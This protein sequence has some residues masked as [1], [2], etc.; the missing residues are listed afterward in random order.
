V[1][2][3]VIVIAADGMEI[4]LLIEE[5]TSGTQVKARPDVQVPVALRFVPTTRWIFAVDSVN[6]LSHLEGKNVSVLADGYVIASP[7]NSDYDVL[8]VTG[9]T[10]NLPKP[11]GVI[12]VG[13]PYISDLE[14]LDIDTPSGPS[15]KTRKIS[16]ANVVLEVEKSRGG[17][18]G[19]PTGPT[20]TDPLNGLDE[21]KY[22]GDEDDE[23]GPVQFKTD[24]VEVNTEATW[25]N[26]GRRFVRQ[27][28]PLPLTVLAIIPEGYI[29]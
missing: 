26:H 14:T 18:A 24:S 13:L 19:P 10:I 3:A 12:R 27:V 23:Y 29:G 8:T 25:D 21:F 9:G 16:V 7:N 17:F 15:L 4:R 6:G 2:N 11:Y 28:D 1:G 20:A 5:Y 22:R